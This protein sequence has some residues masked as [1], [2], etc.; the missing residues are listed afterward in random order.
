[1]LG[2][3]RFVLS[4]SASCSLALFPSD[5]LPIHPS[6]TS[7]CRS[8]GASPGVPP[9]QGSS[10]LGRCQGESRLSWQRCRARCHAEPPRTRGTARSRRTAAGCCLLNS[11]MP[12]V[13]TQAAP[14]FLSFF[15]LCVP[16]VSLPRPS[17]QG[18]PLPSCSYPGPSQP[19]S[20]APACSLQAQPPPAGSPCACCLSVWVSGSLP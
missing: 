12:C 5:P 3:Q 19:C 17:P 18:E 13:E 20:A 4:L 14:R 16:A 6:N 1:M 8:P 7:E 2:E 11:L 9:G 15:L 10:V